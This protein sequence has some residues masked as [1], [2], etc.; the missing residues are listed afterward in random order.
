VPLED[1]G[2]YSLLST[3]PLTNR[4][5]VLV[6]GFWGSATSTWGQFQELIDDRAVVST[7]LWPKADLYFYGYR[8]AKDFVEASAD[9][10][11]QF[12]RDVYSQS[13]VWSTPNQANL[14][15]VKFNRESPLPYSQLVLIGHSLG[16]VVIRQ[17][18][19]KVLRK[20]KL[21]PEEPPP[22][23]LQKC[24]MRL[25]APAHLGFNPLSYKGLLFR[26]PGWGALLNSFLLFSRSY[27]DIQKGST[28]L[29]GLKSETETFAQQ[30]PD[31]KCLHP[32]LLFGRLKDLVVPGGF[33]CDYPSEFEDGVGHMGICKPTQQFLKPLEFIAYD[34]LERT[35]AP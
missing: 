4:C 25:F 28:L 15:V 5:I 34:L 11:G 12:L 14:N 32:R 17:C 33:A 20:C 24:E 29:Q 30:N 23:W 22:A 31:L 10:L 1:H 13:K 35:T 21:Q 7:E 8:S 19:A 6:H 18:I 16:A 27:S 2:S 26:L 9:D 3:D